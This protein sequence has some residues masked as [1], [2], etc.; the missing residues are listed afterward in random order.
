MLR[1]SPYSDNS[2]PRQIDF[3]APL[4]DHDDAIATLEH[5]T[6][7]RDGEEQ[8]DKR[9]VISKVLDNYLL[10]YLQSC[11]DPKQARRHLPIL[12]LATFK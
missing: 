10:T 3:V 12:H 9:Q 11:P 5:Y 1:L 6:S 2:T 7:Y 8:N 4:N